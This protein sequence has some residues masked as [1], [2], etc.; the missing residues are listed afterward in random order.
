M[1]KY[2]FPHPMMNDEV[3]EK[4]YSTNIDSG[5]WL[6]RDQQSDFYKYSYF[7][8]NLTRKNIKNLF[9]SWDGKDFY[10]DENILENL[11]LNSNNK[12][13][14]TIDHKLS[15]KYGF[16][17]KIDPKKIASIE[18]LCITTRSNNSSKN[19]KCEL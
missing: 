9:N 8:I 4:S 6:P 15:I 19:S 14:P 5:R 1:K 18:N 12:E 13:Y 3:K 17:N 11:T 2:G 7:V 16:D 10:S